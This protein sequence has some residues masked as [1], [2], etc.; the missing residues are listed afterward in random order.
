MTVHWYSP[1]NQLISTDM[2]ASG[3]K[4]W[5]Y[6]GIYDVM[7]MDFNGNSNLA[8]RSKGTRETF[9]VY[10]IRATGTY[11]E[12]VPQLPGGEVTVAE[13]YPYQF[14]IDSRSQEINLEEVSGTEGVEVHFYP[15][16]VLREFTFMVYDV[17]GSKNMARNGGAISGMSGS[18]FPASGRLATEPSTILFTR[19]EAVPNAQIS[20]RWTEAEKAL[21]AAKNPDWASTDTLVGWTRDWVVGKF[22][23]FGPIP[24]EGNRFR[25][26]I[27]TVSK[28][29]N[30]YHGSW[31]YWHG[32]WEDTV[33]DQINGA[34]GQT[35]ST[36]EQEAWRRK[37]GG[38]DI[39]LY[40]DHRLQ[41]PEGDTGN[42][43]STDG[44]F[45]VGVDD[46][47]DIIDIP[48]AGNTETD[49][50]ETRA[51][52]NTTATI[53]DFVVNGIHKDESNAYSFIF[54]E[55]YIYKPESG[56]IWDYYP[57]KYW[58]QGGEVN[59][60]A[61]AP[62]GI[63]NFVTGLNNKGGD[64]NPPVL[65]YIMPY[66]NREEPPRGS[67]EPEPVK[68][69][70]QNQEDLLVAKHTY[71]SP[72]T[73]AVALNFT[74]AFSRVTARAKTKELYSD[75]RIKVVRL[76]LRN[77]YSKGKFNFI[78]GTETV[79]SPVPP[80]T[81]E[82]YNTVEEA[83]PATYRFNLI[84]PAIPIDEQYTT[85][86]GTNDG[87]F[88]MPQTVGN[89]AEIYVEY[90]VYEISPVYGEVYYT[91]AKKLLQIT[92]GFEFQ[93]GK[94]YKIQVDLEVPPDNP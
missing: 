77:L 3:G 39:V 54:N 78:K 2:S 73:G 37:N 15:E 25:L 52:V 11:N 84:A 69:V 31:G 44:G 22:V 36:E 85:L 70:H 20:T 72:Q 51:P 58:P 62:A 43:G 74:H 63:K 68:I 80:G 66:V 13:A 7:C 38:F 50:A 81:W 88:V 5:L 71:P 75:R 6:A 19:V 55:Q 59:F 9:E 30:T 60:Y 40:N 86:T 26:A 27:E 67:G 91:S 24:T 61:Y 94:Q 4:E 8:F 48:T 29:S 64:G 82:Y 12:Y 10:N 92:A 46:W 35:R 23:T 56:L 83:Q 17:T 28:G 33:L 47:G 42:S 79:P 16:N 1:T 18:Y 87:V 32:E 89:D 21:F 57:K 65:E 41:V 76:E 49:N 14:Y 45:T 34:M 53:P 93:T 90:D